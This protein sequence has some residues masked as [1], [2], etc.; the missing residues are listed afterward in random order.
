MKPSKVSADVRD[1]AN[2][3]SSRSFNT[4]LIRSASLMLPLTAKR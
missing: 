4:K 1:A 2:Q 3:A